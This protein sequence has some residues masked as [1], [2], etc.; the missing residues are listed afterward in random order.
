MALDD[1]KKDDLFGLVM[2]YGNAGVEEIK[3]AEPRYETAPIPEMFKQAME[4]APIEV[5]NTKVLR[6]LISY[7]II[8]KGD[9]V[10]YIDASGNKVT[11][12]YSG[13]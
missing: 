10:T 3:A 7:G 12:T 11:K 13:K 2:M 1:A 9:K 5:S 4:S 6:A 8:K